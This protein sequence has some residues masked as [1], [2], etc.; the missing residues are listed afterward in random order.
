M[1]FFFYLWVIYFDI[2]VVLHLQ[3]YTL[4]F[5]DFLKYDLGCTPKKLENNFLNGNFCT[6]QRDLHVFQKNMWWLKGGFIGIAVYEKFLIIVAA[7]KVLRRFY[8]E[9]YFDPCKTHFQLLKLFYLS[10][11]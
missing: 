11:L 7:I 3:C 1:K 10:F 4:S 2:S 6:N 9:W 8:L 5:S